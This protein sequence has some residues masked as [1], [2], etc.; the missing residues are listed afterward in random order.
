MRKTI[1]AVSIIIPMYNAEKYICDCLDNIL[2]QTFQDFEV[3]IVDDCSTDK[4]C[5]VVESYLPEFNSSGYDKLK[6]LRSKVNSGG[7]GTPRNIGVNIS[8]GEYILFIDSDDFITKT[9]LEEL[10]P[11]AKKFDADVVHCEKYFQ[12]T[13]GQEN[14]KIESYQTGEFVKELLC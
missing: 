10:Y 3:I 9:A 6:L 11:I 8:C 1:P 13:D 5:D 12:F 4:S 2:I 14:F 7:E